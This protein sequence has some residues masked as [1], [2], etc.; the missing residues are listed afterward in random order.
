MRQAIRIIATLLL[1]AVPTQSIA[2]DDA[3]LDALAERIPDVVRQLES[4]SPEDPR[5]YFELAETVAGEASDAAGIRLARRLLVLAFHL[6]TDADSGLQP[7]ICLTLAA[8]ESSSADRQWLRALAGS[9]DPRYS[10]DAANATRRQLD[11]ETQ[12]EAAET[13][14]AARAGRGVLVRQRLREPDILLA[15]DGQADRLGVADGDS[16]AA[17]LLAMARSWP[18]REC[19]NRRAQTSRVGDSRSTRICPACN[20]NPGPTLTR[21]QLV[22][23]V[24]AEARL[25]EASARSWAAQ[26]EIDA[27]AA[28]RDVDPAG[29]DRLYSIETDR[30]LFRD[31][32]WVEPEPALDS[33]EPEPK[34]TTSEEPTDE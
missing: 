27:A 10:D 5:A 6:A 11:A 32:A 16:V 31:G 9:L 30:V 3:D 22:R 28:F 7:S 34:Q 20:G 15:L 26:V 23:L 14:A 33:P 17:R 24:R 1:L 2:A 19:S 12:L 8:I 29:I 13:L 21:S 25:L 4:L 18:C